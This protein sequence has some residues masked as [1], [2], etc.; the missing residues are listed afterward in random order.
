MVLRN[1]YVVSIQQK[2]KALDRIANIMLKTCAGQLAPALTNIFQ[3]S[4]LLN[5]NISSVYE[6]GDVHLPEIYRLM[7]LTCVSGMILEHMV[8]KHILDHTDPNKNLYFTQP[9]L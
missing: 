5:T 6:K 9:W 2:P 8:C 1:F 7:S 4:D 3:P